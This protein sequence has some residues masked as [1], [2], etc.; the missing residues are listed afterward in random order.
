MPSPLTPR[1]GVATGIDKCRE[2][3]EEKERA[4][5]R[6]R[7]GNEEEEKKKKNH[8]F[9]VALQNGYH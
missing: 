6:P 5:K 8:L 9:C 2:E 4:I 1:H 7:T 3:E